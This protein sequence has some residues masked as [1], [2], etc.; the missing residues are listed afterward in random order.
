MSHSHPST[1]WRRQGWR[2]E[3]SPSRRRRPVWSLAPHTLIAEGGVPMPSRRRR[4]TIWPA[5]GLFDQ[6]RVVGQT[7]R[8]ADG[9]GTRRSAIS[10][11]GASGTTPGPVAGAGSKKRCSRANLTAHDVLGASETS[12]GPRFDAAAIA[13]N[14]C[15]ASVV[16]MNYAVRRR[17][18]GRHGAVHA[19]M[20]PAT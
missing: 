17:N 11:I 16:Q 6:S 15:R 20:P 4:R 19:R 18:G 2:R 12:T 8:D 3:P 5:D 1:S 10:G 13:V 7:R 14:G 9:I